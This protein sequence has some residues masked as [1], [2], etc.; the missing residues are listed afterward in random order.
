MKTL[1]N[2]NDILNKNNFSVNENLIS[3][4][5]SKNFYIQKY[6][7]E[8]Y[9]IKE[10]KKINEI[11]YFTALVIGKS[12]VWKSCLINNI[13]KLKV[14]ENEAYTSDRVNGIRC[15]DTPGCDLNDVGHT[16]TDC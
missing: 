12:G 15:I 13:L 6:K 1:I 14:P 9:N 16:I 10:D 3:R 5:I 4:E 11:K 8:I 7:R 2:Q